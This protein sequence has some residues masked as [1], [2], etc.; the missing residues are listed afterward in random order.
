M[1]IGY[2][3]NNYPEKRTI[4]GKV[5]NTLY[6]KI[7]KK[8]NIYFYISLLEKFF[9]GKRTVAN[10]FKYKGLLKKDVDI[11]HFFNDINYV[12]EEYVTT[13]ETCVPRIDMFMQ[14]YN[15]KMNINSNNIEKE[16]NILAKNNCKALLAI[17]NCT[18]KYN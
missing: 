1:K 8:N 6:K 13:F 11:Y 16:L 3:K 2:I 14:N 9:K 17:S 12:K 4:I 15:N 5:D 18:K 10:Y 7:S